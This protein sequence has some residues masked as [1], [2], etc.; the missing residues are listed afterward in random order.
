VLNDF[1]LL[2][3]TIQTLCKYSRFLCLG[4]PTAVSNLR[5]WGERP[6]KYEFEEVRA[7]TA[8]PHAKPP[9]FSHQTLRS[10]GGPPRGRDKE[11]T[12]RERSEGTSTGLA[13]AMYSVKFDIDRINDVDSV[14]V[15]K[16]QFHI[17]SPVHLKHCCATAL[18]VVL[19]LLRQSLDVMD[20]IANKHA[21]TAKCGFHRTGSLWSV[22]GQKSAFPIHF[23]NCPQQS[24]KR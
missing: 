13:N 11:K 15:R 23:N 18:H 21:E 8:H 17:D 3:P 1:S 7:Q 12:E 16:S 20:L 5:F 2:S 19:A 22:I 10:V 4:I 6:P 24:A 14:E 9:C